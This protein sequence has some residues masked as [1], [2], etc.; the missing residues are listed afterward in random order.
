MNNFWI[1]FSH[2]Y[3]TKIKSRQ[4]LITTVI[5]L[6]LI[7]LMTELPNLIKKFNGS[8]E[9][10]IVLVDQTKQLAQPFTQMMEKTDKHITIVQRTAN[11]E[12]LRKQ[13]LNG[14]VDGYLILSFGADGLPKAVF[15]TKSLTDQSLADQLQSVLQQIRSQQAAQH[16]NLSQEQL[17]Q[18][19][20][21][22]D[23]HHVAVEKQAK[24]EKELS[25]ARGLVYALLIIIY[26]AVIMYA[27]MIATEVATEKS[28]RVMEIL[29]SSVSPVTHMFAKIAGVVFVGLTQLIIIFGFG[30]YA[31][32]SNLE[33][34]SGGFFD[35]FGFGD[36]SFVIML[37]GL[38]FFILGFL[39]YA[40]IAAF[41]G[42]LT[43]RIEDVN[44]MISPLTF[45]IVLAFMLAIFGLNNPEAPFVTVTSFI[46]FFTPMLMFLRVG[47]LDL[48]L[49]QTLLSIGLLIASIVILA[50]FGARVYKGGVLMYG[51]SNLLKEMKKA[52]QLSKENK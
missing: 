36:S 6:A 27:T 13:V 48:P 37:Y 16:L 10:T 7:L 26:F 24:S 25:Q 29:I 35:F 22:V 4:F 51:R 14:D 28:S 20:A 42:S 41:L 39:L 19:K 8:D 50:V 11:E 33:K 47:M 43:S 32:K 23:F 46:P 31:I 1:V 2:T 49:W 5:I 52:L 18:L 44:Q 15:K 17:A 3:L 9:K 34:M 30:Y 45:L 40:T 12:K 38:L 21:P